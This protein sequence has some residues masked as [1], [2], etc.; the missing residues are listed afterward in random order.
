[1]WDLAYASRIVR[2]LGY[3]GL[4]GHA[5]VDLIL[6]PFIQNLDSYPVVLAIYGVTNCLLIGLLLAYGRRL[7]GRW[8]PGRR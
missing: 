1:M 4:F 2:I 3:A 5:A 7:L 8:R 6:A